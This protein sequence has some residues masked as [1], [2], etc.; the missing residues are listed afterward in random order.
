[1]GNCK[2]GKSASGRRG[3]GLAFDL[4]VDAGPLEGLLHVGPANLALA[5]DNQ[6]RAPENIGKDTEH[7]GYVE[8]GTCDH[9]GS[10]IGDTKLVIVGLRFD[11]IECLKAADIEALHKT[12][13]NPE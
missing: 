8:R 2:D 7:A 10:A 6:L 3:A 13:H 5:P 4:R 12:R 9:C 11:S 1:M